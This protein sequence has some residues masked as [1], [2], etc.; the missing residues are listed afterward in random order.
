M[1][2]DEERR[3]GERLELEYAQQSNAVINLWVDRQIA[4]CEHDYKDRP[5][6]NPTL[7]H[8]HDN[9]YIDGEQQCYN[10]GNN[11]MFK[12]GENVTKTIWEAV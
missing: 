7:K 1:T 11:R 6:R 12:D 8:T 9:L 10:C 5:E 2:E 4:Q 3:I